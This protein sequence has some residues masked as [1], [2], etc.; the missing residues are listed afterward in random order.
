[1]ILL[2][3]LIESIRNENNKIRQNLFLSIEYLIINLN[4][5]LPIIVNR[6]TGS[7]KYY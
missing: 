3:E 6:D 1:M 2:S 5:F 4:H 7:D